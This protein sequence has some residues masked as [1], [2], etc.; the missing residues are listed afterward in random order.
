MADDRRKLDHL[1]FGQVPLPPEVRLHVGPER[2]EGV[3]GVHD[4]VDESVEQGAQGLVT[5]GDESK[6]NMLSVIF[7]IN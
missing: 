1:H 4:N 3:V 7:T 2:G 5:T 6:K